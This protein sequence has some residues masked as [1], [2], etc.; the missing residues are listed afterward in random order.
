MSKI[1][2]F[3][4]Y[5][6]CGKDTCCKLLQQ[7]SSKKIV[8]LSFAE[9]V[10]KTVWELFKEKIKDRNRI[11]GTIDQKESL[12]NG[13]V[14]P[15]SLDYPEKYWS[16]RRL[17]QWFGTDVCRSIYENI[18]VDNLMAEINDTIWNATE[19][20]DICITDCRFLNEYEAL[21]NL[22]NTIFVRI[23]RKHICN[24]FSGHSSELDMAMFQPNITI[25]NDGNIEDLKYNL[26]KLDELY[27]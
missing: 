16:G 23:E 11:W 21:K 25:N 8:Q 24:K 1:I 22:D 12:I 14:L 7:L 19:D 10:R 5:K 3:Y 20:V 27:Q 4:G 2:V 26:K 9:K 6:G 13:W 17:L 18:W 15:L